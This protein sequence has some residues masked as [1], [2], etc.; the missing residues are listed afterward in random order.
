MFPTL[1]NITA[2]K[3][4]AISENVPANVIIVYMYAWLKTLSGVFVKI[5]SGFVR[6]KPAIVIAIVKRT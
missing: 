3:T 2:N 4:Y 1:F 5:N 6:I